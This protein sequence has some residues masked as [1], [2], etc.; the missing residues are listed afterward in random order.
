M[1]DIDDRYI[2]YA[3]TAKATHVVYLNPN[4]QQHEEL[5]PIKNM[6]FDK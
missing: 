2:K 1:C 5:Q 4:L 3:F 6:N